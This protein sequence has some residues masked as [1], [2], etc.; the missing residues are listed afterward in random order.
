MHD[1][2]RILL[3]VLAGLTM[4]GAVAGAASVLTV[5]GGVMQSGVDTDL[6][7][8]ADGVYLSY[9]PEHTGGITSAK[10]ND[11]HTP[12]A[13]QKLVVSFNDATPLRASG[14]FTS[15]AGAATSAI[16]PCLHNQPPKQPATRHRGP[17]PPPAT[18]QAH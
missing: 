1:M 12:C 6:T 18:P 7:C 9:A 17:T 11:I 3:A 10:I 16:T 13:G 4:T 2:K 15:P 14:I 5:D 8:D